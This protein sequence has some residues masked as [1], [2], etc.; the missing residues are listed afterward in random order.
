MI[1]MLRLKAKVMPNKTIEK[2][3]TNLTLDDKVDTKSSAASFAIL[4]SFELQLLKISKLRL[5]SVIL[6]FTAQLFFFSGGAGRRV[7]DHSV[8]A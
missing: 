3:S 8:H 1:Q 5:F 4:L 2:R 7:E 6:S